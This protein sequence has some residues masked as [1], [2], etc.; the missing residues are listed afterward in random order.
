M[1]NKLWYSGFYFNWVTLRLNLITSP[2]LTSS[3]WT[4]TSTMKAV[5]VERRASDVEY[6]LVSTFGSRQT[7][8]RKTRQ[9]ME[10]ALLLQRQSLGMCLKV[11]L[12]INMHRNSSCT[13]RYVVKIFLVNW[14]IKIKG[15]CYAHIHSVSFAK[16]HHPLIHK[17]QPSTSS[18]ATTFGQN[19]IHYDHQWYTHPTC[20]GL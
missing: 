7:A 4:L 14:D 19:L 9:V 10:C 20:V 15:Q 2:S 16:H 6:V 8:A 12:M 1:G 13:L 5:S 17:L 3:H 11:L 18:P